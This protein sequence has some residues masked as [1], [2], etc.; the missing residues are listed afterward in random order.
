MNLS[1]LLNMAHFLLQQQL[2]FPAIFGQAFILSIAVLHFAH[3][4]IF[5]F[6]QLYC[7][8]ARNTKRFTYIRIPWIFQNLALLFSLHYRNFKSRIH[9]Q[10]YKSYIKKNT[11]TIYRI[12]AL[13]GYRKK[14][15]INQA[16]SGM[17]WWMI[18]SYA[19]R[20]SFIASNF[21]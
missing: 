1:Q 19:Y 14:K 20:M 9:T 12:S 7:F 8:A 11:M 6:L 18:I 10:K 4:T 21:A 17:H 13:L 16:N 2:H 3:N 15:S 5:Q